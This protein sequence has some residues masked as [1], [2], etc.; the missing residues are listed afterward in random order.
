MPWDGPACAQCG[1]PFASAR[2]LDAEPSLCG[3]CRSG[4]QSFDRARSFGLYTDRLRQAILLMKFRRRDRLGKKLGGFLLPVWESVEELRTA[5]DP[6]VLPVPLHASRQRER[7]FNQAEVLARGLVR[8]LSS[9]TAGRGPRLETHCLRRTR[10]TPPQTGLSLRERRE[11]VRGVFE[12]M[13]PQTL[14]GRVVV[15]VDDVMTTGATLSACARAVR[16]AAPAR[17]V[18]LT[19]AR[20]TPQFPGQDVSDPFLPVDEA[21]PS[22]T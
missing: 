16:E 6:V 5:D 22:W 18:A 4:E 3:S 21:G 7:G 17:I 20:A 1:V 2:A 13:R 14:R 15:L 10:P 8:A 19:L 11:N 12:V 9:R